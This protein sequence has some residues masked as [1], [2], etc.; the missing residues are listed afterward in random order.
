[1][2]YVYRIVSIPLI[3]LSFSA[4]SKDN[5]EPVSIQAQNKSILNPKPMKE[6]LELPLPCQ[7][8]EYKI[9]F[10][11]VYTDYSGSTET[12]NGFVFY[13]GSDDPKRALIEGKR[14][15][16]VKGNF[17]DEKGHFYYL[18]KYELTSSQYDAINF[19]KCKEKLTN[20]D[21][22]PK[23]NVSFDEANMTASYLSAYLQSIS[24]TPTNEAGEKATAN[25][26]YECYWAFA[27][28]GG[29]SVDKEKL[30]QNKPYLHENTKIEDYVWFNSPNSANNKLQVI[31]LKKPNILGFFDMLGN[32]SEY[33]FEPFQTTNEQ[34]LSGQIGGVTVRGGGYLTPKAQITNSLRT[35]RKRYT[36]GKPSFSRDTGF[37]LMLNVS[38]I[39]DIESLRSENKAINEKQTL[40]DELNTK[41]NAE[42]EQLCPNKI[43]SACFILGSNY[44]NGK[45]SDIDLT[46]AATAY[47]K[48]CDNDE[49][50]SCTNLGYLYFKGQGVKMDRKEAANL[51][52]KA[53]KNDNYRAC[54]ALGSM[55]LVGRGVRLDASYAKDLLKKACDGGDQQSCQKLQLIK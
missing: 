1:M 20:E 39:K 8:S 55:H 35:E 46:K 41:N 21:R 12:T 27:L 51:F 25:L 50:N 53:C 19:G 10:R 4:M 15:C 42:L 7:N 47:H 45:N 30:E 52:Y 37:R 18:A 23:V 49:I 28:R 44:E 43:P 16:V 24:E 40:L 6:D 9:V 29:L 2:V 33:I 13:E 3:L 34:G 54:G 26:P 48:G 32:A 36:E 11:K 22:L 17:K 38:A 5:A 31:G 14:K